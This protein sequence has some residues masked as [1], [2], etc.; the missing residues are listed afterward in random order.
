MIQGVPI[1]KGTEILIC[2]AAIHRN[3]R[4]WGPDAD[5]FDP[6]RWDKLEGDAAD[7]HAWAPFL[8]G[9]RACI[10]RTLAWLEFKA[11]V[12]ELVRRFTFERIMEGKIGLVNPSPVLRPAGGLRVKV[13]RRE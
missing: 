11:V 9:P 6:A 12:V 4:I 13:V 2:P 5:E 8:Q 1:R 10:G 3:P 7:V